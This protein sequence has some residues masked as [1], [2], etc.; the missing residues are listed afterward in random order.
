MQK[1]FTT[2]DLCLANTLQLLGYVVERID[3]TN[4]RKAEFVFKDSDALRVDIKKFWDGELRVSPLEFYQ[5]LRMLKA[6]L[7]D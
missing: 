6:R 4:P 1:E 2:Y 3:K 5:Q 7:Y